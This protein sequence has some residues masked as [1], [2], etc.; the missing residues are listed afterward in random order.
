MSYVP[1][2]PSILPVQR[3]SQAQVRAVGLGQGAGG[4]TYIECGGQEEGQIGDEIICCPPK[5]WSNA[6]YKAI[7]G[8]TSLQYY[9]EKRVRHLLDLLL[10]PTEVDPTGVH[11]YA[12]DRGLP[13]PD[14]KLITGLERA[15]FN[16]RQLIPKDR[17]W[18][19]DESEPTDC[20]TDGYYGR[21]KVSPGAI[22]TRQPRGAS[23]E[24]QQAYQDVTQGRSAEDVRQAA[25]KVINSV[26]GSG[27][28]KKRG[29]LPTLDDVLQVCDPGVVCG[30]T[31]LEQFLAVFAPDYAQLPKIPIQEI[32]L[33]KNAVAD[34]QEART[35]AAEEARTQADEEDPDEG[36]GMGLLVAGGLLVVGVGIWAVSR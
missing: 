13:D 17:W 16:F 21:W 28:S 30:T 36:P 14:P 31:W 29:T 7:L 35:Q 20:Q 2:A 8:K 4:A 15:A 24:F 6:T 25:S 26:P 19:E 12:Y 18:R 10:S 22:G 9:N 23:Q 11:Q 27:P 1:I 33:P 32:P 3:R 34:M 5:T